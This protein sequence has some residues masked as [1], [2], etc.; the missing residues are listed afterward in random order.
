M[1]YLGLI[2]TSEAYNKFSNSEEFAQPPNPIQ[3]RLT[4][5]STKPTT[6]RTR[7]HAASTESEI[8]APNVTFTHANIARRK[9]SHEEELGL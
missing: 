9:A 6:K 2:L 1:G 5:D 3:F 4:V 7:A 8:D